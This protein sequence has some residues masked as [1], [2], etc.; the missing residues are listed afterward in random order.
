MEEAD[1][2]RKGPLPG[3]CTIR[4]AYAKS[5]NTVPFKISSDQ[6]LRSEMQSFL[7]AWLGDSLGLSKE[8][9]KLLEKNTEKSDL[10]FGT[11]GGHFSEMID[12]VIK[13][14]LL[15]KK[16]MEYLF[17]KNK[18]DDINKMRSAPFSKTAASPKN[19]KKGNPF[20]IYGQRTNGFASVRKDRN[21]NTNNAI[22]VVSL[23]PFA[24]QEDE[25]PRESYIPALNT[26]NELYEK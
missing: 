16:A 25:E 3:N 5:N 2:G 4:A 11:R 8:K 22:S 13:N 12:I 20:A 21:S 10:F 17:K 14:P 6:N 1:F 9:I 19:K 15:H 7:L 18:A 26:S 24:K 23:N